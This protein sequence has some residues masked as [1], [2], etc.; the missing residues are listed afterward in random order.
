[1]KF[2]TLDD[3]SAISEV[4]LTVI[5]TAGET[6]FSTP[7]YERCAGALRYVDRLLDIGE[8]CRESMIYGSYQSE[9]FGGRY[10]FYCPRGFVYFVS[11]IIRGGRHDLSAIGGPLLMTDHDDYIEFDIAKKVGR[12]N[13]KE[14]RRA[15]SCV[16]VKDAR[17]ITA[18]SEQLFVNALH[19]SDSDYITYNLEDSGERLNEYLRSYAERVK[20]MSDMRPFEEEKKLIEA[21]SRHEEYPARALLNDILGHILF[22][23]GKNLELVRGRIMGLVILLS[24]AALRDGA[25]T[26][27]I[28]GLNYSCLR[29]ID[30]L[31]SIDDIVVWLNDMMKRFSD[32]IFNFPD[33][34]HADLI[35]KVVGFMNQNFHKKITLYEAARFV[36]MSPPYLSRIFKEETG[37]SFNNYLNIIRIEHSKK[38]LADLSVSLI[39][40]TGLVGYEDQ[41]YF[42][43][44]FKKHEGVSPRQYRE[45]QRA[46]AGFDVSAKAGAGGSRGRSEGQPM[47][48]SR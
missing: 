14:L 35:R 34:K 2:D 1:M 15:V 40:I 48:L 5:D 16:P 10:I 3:F 38:L 33:A 31:S 13:W 8:Q 22:H 28:F 6:L 46:D 45:L 9:R 42:A 25:D 41:S 7:A 24:K 26:E 20:G 23:S 37:C 17:L 30:D 43:K 29:E 18:L 32:S 47:V 39:D 11:P 4:G 21:L 27:F 36:F 44:V 19:L 12:F